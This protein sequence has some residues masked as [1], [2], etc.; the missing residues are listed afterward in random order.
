[1]HYPFNYAPPCRGHF[2]LEPKKNRWHFL[3]VSQ[4]FFCIDDISFQVMA[5]RDALSIFF[6]GEFPV[7]LEDSPSPWLALQ[8]LKNQDLQLVKRTWM[9]FKRHFWASKADTRLKYTDGEQERWISNSIHQHYRV[10]NAKSYIIIAWKKHQLFLVKKVQKFRIIISF[11]HSVSQSLI[12]VLA[13][14]APLI[15]FWKGIKESA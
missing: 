13:P 15:V 4:L 9:H 8:V 5:T 11:K 10:S 6:K 14:L 3:H 2:L 12:R 1:M 7:V